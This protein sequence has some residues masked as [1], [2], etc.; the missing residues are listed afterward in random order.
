MKAQGRWEARKP[1]FFVNKKEAKKTLW[2]WVGAGFDAT[3]PT[4]EVFCCFFFQKSSFF[5]SSLIAR[6][7][8]SISGIQSRVK[9]Q[10]RLEA[11]K[12]F[13]FVNKKEAKKTLWRW[14]C[15][16][17]D[18]TTPTSEVFCCFFS[19]KQFFL[20]F[21]DRAKPPFD[22]PDIAGA[23]RLL[24]WAGDPALIIAPSGSAR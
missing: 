12:P 21:I 24:G 6:N 2:R 10:G 5:L 22:I 14:V 11:R 4:S 20:I 8:R 18:A 19:K 13:F 1:F 17:F 23:R 15:A 3:T 7:R 9:A 16:G